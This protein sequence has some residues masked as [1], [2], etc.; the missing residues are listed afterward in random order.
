MSRAGWIALAAGI[1]LTLA[2]TAPARD[3]AQDVKSIV[4]AEAALCAAFEA[5][6]GDV[7]RDNLTDGFTMTDAKGKIAN[8]D[9]T[10]AEVRRR[11]PVYVVFQKHDQTV[12]V[13]GDAAVVTGVTSMQGHSG[14]GSKFEGDYAYTDTWVHS[15]GRW[16]L[17]ASHATLL[18]TR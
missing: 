6:D 12:R 5:S 8:R 10:V 18:R 7:L 14:G 16:K 3:A 17:A 1:A 9:Q 2:G 13:Y 15:D 4:R 11:D